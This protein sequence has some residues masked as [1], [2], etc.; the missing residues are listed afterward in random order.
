MNDTI[1]NNLS[2]IGIIITT[3]IFVVVVLY[4]T[5]PT[6]RVEGT[7]ESGSI[8]G[9]LL[10]VD[11]EDGCG[12]MIWCQTIIWLKEHPNTV[13]H[14]GEPCHIVGMLPLNTTYTFEYEPFVNMDCSGD[15]FWDIR[16]CKIYD[17]HGDCFWR[18][19]GFEG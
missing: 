9:T 17:V 11:I 18:Y 6:F 3:S 12:D 15:N 16:I 1:K 5:T 14:F 8:T 4:F 7:K 10:K 2:V 19:S 13:Y